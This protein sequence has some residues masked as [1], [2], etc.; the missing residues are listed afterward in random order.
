MS[1]DAWQAGGFNEF[2][3]GNPDR[4]SHHDNVE[5]PQ[6]VLAALREGLRPMIAELVREVLS[7]PEVASLA[8]ISEERPPIDQPTD[9]ASDWM[10]VKPA[11]A[12]MG[13]HPVTVRK[14]LESEQLLGYQ[15]KEP[16]GD[17][18]IHRDDCGR[19]MRGLDTVKQQRERIGLKQ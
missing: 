19:F 16:K 9:L 7:H 13:R 15:R 1:V 10:S 12:H 4:M 8:G 6:Q 5:I 11:A 18:R 17:W 2:E 14:G 3:S